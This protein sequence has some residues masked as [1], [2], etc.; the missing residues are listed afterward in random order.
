[1]LRRYKAVPERLDVGARIG[2]EVESSASGVGHQQ[3]RRRDAVHCGAMS[4]TDTPSVPPPP[5]PS[6][7]ELDRLKP[8][9]D[10]FTPYAARKSQER[11]PTKESR[12]PFVHYTSAEAALSII[13]EKRLW[14]RRTSCMM[15][16][17][18]VQHGFEMLN[19]L[20]DPVVKP[21][22]DE[23]DK[24]I[25][26]AGTQ[27]LQIFNR[28]WSQIRDHTYITSLSEHDGRENLHGRLSMWR[29]FG[30]SAVPRVAL[31]FLL[32]WYTE[33]IQ[34]LHLIF[35]PVGY[36]TEEEIARQMGEVMDNIRGNLG[37][38]RS[39]DPRWIFGCS[40][41]MLLLAVTCVKHEGFHEEREWRAIH[42]PTRWGTTLIRPVRKIVSGVPQIV[43]ELPLDA[44][45][46]DNIA[47]LDLARVLD[48]II[49]GPTQ[50][51]L[52]VAEAF[53]AALAD[54]GVPDP[55]KKVWASTIPI[56]T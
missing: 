16:Y 53:V 34:H 46:S 2:H 1:M 43:Y 22:M 47:E 7:E 27:A 35:S 13:K 38:L 36:F 42:Q 19:R 40:F 6:R 49:I 4:S 41:A 51:P 24:Y 52:S 29:A 44:A 32:P 50:Y 55:D 26:G 56:R 9:F 14:M 8:I 3:I 10:L 25:D 18:E 12:A 17:R 54:A 28:D 20:F 37:L 45:V 31:V 23:L 30:T 5:P 48:R 33:A 39:V 15:D 21:F 11:Y